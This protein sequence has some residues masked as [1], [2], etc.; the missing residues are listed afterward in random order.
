MRLTAGQLAELSASVEAHCSRLRLL[1]WRIQDERID[2][3]DLKRALDAAWGGLAE[4]HEVIEGRRG[5]RLG[6]WYY[7]NIRHRGR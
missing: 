5:I 6:D 2:E 4:L 1:A 3:P 7:G